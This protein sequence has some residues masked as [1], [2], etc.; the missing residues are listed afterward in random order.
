MAEKHKCAF[1]II[2]RLALFCKLCY[3]LDK[4]ANITQVSKIQTL[5]QI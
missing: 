4:N 2:L 5:R 3:L 1:D